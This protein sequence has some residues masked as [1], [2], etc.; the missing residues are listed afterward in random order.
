MSSNYNNY[1]GLPPLDGQ[2]DDDDQAHAQPPGVHAPSARPWPPVPPSGGYVP[3]GQ[4]EPWSAS[5]VGDTN[6]LSPGFTGQYAAAPQQ[7]SSWAAVSASVESTLPS[8]GQ[9]PGFRDAP[10]TNASSMNWATESDLIESCQV[11]YD[12]ISHELDELRMLLTQSGKEMEKLNQRKVLTAAQVREIEEHLEL[13]SRQEI[14]E[15]YLAAAEA[16]M[17]AFMIGEQRE[18]MQSK[19]HTYEQYLDFLRRTVDVLQAAPAP[20]SGASSLAGSGGNGPNGQAAPAWPALPDIPTT[21]LVNPA[22]SSVVS[23]SAVMPALSSQLDAV[24]RMIQAQEGIRERVAQRLHDGPT[25][26]LANVVLTAEICEK[27]VQSDPRRALSE[28]GNLKVLVNTTLQ[29][30]R[31]FIF[32]LRPMTLNDLGLVATLR[33]YTADTAARYQ[34]RIPLAAPQGERRMPKEA[35]VAVFRVAQEAILNAVTHSRATII[36]VLVAWP[37]DGFVLVVEDNGVGFNVEQALA[38]AINRQTIGITNMQERA[39]MLGGWLRI[40]S[41]PGH[42]TRIELSFPSAQDQADKTFGAVPR[43]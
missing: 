11:E 40:E 37:P 24:T 39:E 23:L 33:R 43:Y 8:N 1:P 20:A 31:K 27:L 19:A 2:R 7:T 17:R 15:K 35:E 10:A 26:S 32:E 12:N 41:T 38:R 14:R 21:A 42:G 28:L 9:P 4:S 13:H 30:T 34:V 22:A 6:V 25:Q 29:E 3:G 16:E 18:Q 36:Q 5:A